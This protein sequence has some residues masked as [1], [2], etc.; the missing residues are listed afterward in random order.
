MTALPD[1]P[2]SPNALTTGNLKPTRVPGA[3]LGAVNFS[4]PQPPAGTPR[5][6]CVV[7]AADGEPTGP[8]VP[9]QLLTVFGSGLGPA[10]PVAATNN[11]TTSLAGVALNADGTVNS[12][13]NPAKLGSV[14]TVFANGIAYNPENAGGLPHLLT[15]A[16][17]SIT[18]IALTSPFVLQ[19][20]LQVPASTDN[21]ECPAPNSSACLGSFGVD[22]LD[23]FLSGD[24]FGGTGGVG[25][26]GLVYVAP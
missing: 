15:G 10:K 18:N 1:F 8:I 12:P 6:G 13:T 19:V 17:W 9:K 25:F 3:Y 22:D 26:G 23:S 16:G 5:I 2:F 24:Q 11:T 14:I 4:A 21:M 7:D 20:S